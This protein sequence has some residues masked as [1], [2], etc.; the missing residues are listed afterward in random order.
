MKARGLVALFLITVLGAAT[1]FAQE[2]PADGE[3]TLPAAA[4]DVP[5]LIDEQLSLWLAL[6]AVDRTIV[7]LQ[8]ERRALSDAQRVKFTKEI[9]GLKI[10]ITHCGQMR[11]KYRVCNVTRRPAQTQTLVRSAPPC[12]WVGVGLNLALVCWVKLWERLTGS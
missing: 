7:G 12:C 3:E 10:E 5:C 2:A 8:R 9:R 6:E 1:L 4:K 11:R